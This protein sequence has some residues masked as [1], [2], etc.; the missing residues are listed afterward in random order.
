M[1]ENAPIQRSYFSPNDGLSNAPR[2]ATSQ[3]SQASQAEAE[4]ANVPQ[5]DDVSY[6]LL[7]DQWRI[8]AADEQNALTGGADATQLVGQ[9]ARDALGDA[10]LFALATDG[11]A[12]FIL[13][14]IEYALTLTTFVTP[15]GLLRLV[16]AQETQAT[17]E[18][19]LSLI[20][21]EVRNP[22][23]A[24]RALAQGLAEDYADTIQA[25]APASANDMAADAASQK[26]TIGAYV[27]RLTGE[28]DRLGRLLASMAQVARPGERPLTTLDPA[29]ALNRA[30][31][32]FSADLERRGVT[33]RVHV[34]PHTT[35]ILADADQLQQA[36]VNLIT[37]ALDAMPH[38][39]SLTLRARLDP[40]RRPVIQVEDIGVGMTPEAIE[41]AF[42]P[43]QSAHSSKP[44]GMGLGLMVVGSIVRQ[45]HGQLRVTSAPGQGTTVSI[46]FPRVE[47]A[48]NE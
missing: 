13:D 12:T 30:A 31:A 43:R 29:L 33:L 26:P 35:P 10:T 27:G 24:M 21:H 16:R 45:H 40:R 22:L 44:G 47:T 5:R 28:I 2:R 1:T 25:T 7:D 34:T 9:Q 48:Q 11:A 46:T 18:R 42:R 3:A 6:L 37:N 32:I 36:L 38:G 19:I 8:I 20:V 4:R 39:G 15:T 17:L 23:M 41:R 14:D